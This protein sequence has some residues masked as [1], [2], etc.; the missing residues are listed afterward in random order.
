MVRWRVDDSVGEEST[1][2]G[3]VGFANRG[4]VDS[5]GVEVENNDVGE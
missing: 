2:E 1:E 4:D 3:D 5:N